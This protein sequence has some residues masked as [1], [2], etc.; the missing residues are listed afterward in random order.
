MKQSL[1]K[2]NR[3]GKKSRT[4]YG[5]FQ[6]DW[7]PK[8]KEINLNVTDKQVARKRLNELVYEAEQE[9]F[10]F[11]TGKTFRDAAKIEI[12]DHLNDYLDN[13]TTLGRA[14]R[15]IHNI[16]ARISTVCNASNWQYLRDIKADQYERW[17]NSSKLSGKTLNDYFTD[18]KTFCKWLCDRERLKENPLRIVNKIDMRGKKSNPR[19]A[20]T[21]TEF[22]KILSTADPVCRIAY[23]LAGYC[24]IRRGELEQLKWSDIH[25]DCEEPFI[26]LRASTTKNSL[27]AALPLIHSVA[28]ALL[29]FKP[30]VLTSE[31][32][33]PRLPR[34]RD[35]KPQW[36]AAGIP[37]IDD[38]GRQASFHSLR[39]TFCTMMQMAGVPQR[40]AQEAMRHSDPSLTSNDYTDVSHFNIRA[41][42]EMLPDVLSLDFKK[43]ALI[44]ALEIGN[45]GLD[46]SQTVND[47]RSIIDT[48]VVVSELDR[49]DLSQKVTE[50][51]MVDP[52]GLEPTTRRL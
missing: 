47:G 35:M 13:L 16:G 2:K 39:K 40:I 1:F 51:K 9:E 45:S 21:V 34:F 31:K 22:V 20:L 29:D 11:Q 48:Q 30:K 19:R 28:N 50:N 7:M 33:F 23:L 44:G 8:Y 14:P 27:N 32:V 52:V 17:R 18:F 24:G 41:A 10:G 6:Y 5:R 38:Q 25:L 46:K 37:L 4:W 36:I 49:H 12:T 3:N 43:G 15:Y 26:Y 42:V